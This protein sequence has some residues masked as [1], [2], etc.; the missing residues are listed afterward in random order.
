MQTIYRVVVNQTAEHRVATAEEADALCNELAEHPVF[1][2]NAYTG[3]G[4]DPSFAIIVES[5]RAHVFYMDMTRRVKL[6][7]RD[8]TCIARRTVSLRNEE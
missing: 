1:T 2:A 6:V 4:C 8:Q 7:S 3:Q 5:G